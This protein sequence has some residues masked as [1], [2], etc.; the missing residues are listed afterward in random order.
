MA[1]RQ[2]MF[3][4]S[5]QCRGNSEHFIWLMMPLKA[6]TPITFIAPVVTVPVLSSA[7]IRSDGGLFQEL[8]TFH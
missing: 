2:W 8:A 7:T 1:L 6:S 3:A 4:M 5:F